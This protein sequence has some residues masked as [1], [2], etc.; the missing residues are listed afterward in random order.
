MDYYFDNECYITTS[1]NRNIK[2]DGYTIPSAKN[3]ETIK[4]PNYL[5][6]NSVLKT[7]EIVKNLFEIVGLN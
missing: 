6:K 3:Y 2:I 7:D 4:I 5:V 1:T